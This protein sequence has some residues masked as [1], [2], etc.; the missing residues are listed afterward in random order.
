MV[1]VGVL[2]GRAPSQAGE[3]NPIVPPPSLQKGDRILI[4]ESV[5]LC[6][7]EIHTPCDFARLL[8]RRRSINSSAKNEMRMCGLF[9]PMQRHKAILAG[10]MRL[11]AEWILISSW[12]RFD[13][14]FG[15]CAASAITCRSSSIR[16]WCVTSSPFTKIPSNPRS[17]MRFRQVSSNQSP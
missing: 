17:S 7:S 4:E 10:T 1:A 12:S 5:W 3:G 9:R 15:A 13:V 6:P 2:S 14:S 8:R 16:C 11:R